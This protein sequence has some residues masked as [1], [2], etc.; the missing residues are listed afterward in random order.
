M[1]KSYFV[2]SRIQMFG[3]LVFSCIIFAVATVLSYNFVINMTLIH[4]WPMAL[5][6]L[7]TGYFAFSAWGWGWFTFRSA[8]TRIIIT[9]Q[10]VSLSRLGK[11]IADISWDQ[12]QDLG[13]GLFRYTPGNKHRLYISG[14]H[15]DDELRRH[16]NRIR[17]DCILLPYVSKDVYE[18]LCSFCP[19]QIS[20]E[21]TRLSKANLH[22][23]YRA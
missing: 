15:L 21:V 4:S 14:T 12:V 1:R 5:M 3:K 18:C 23:L 9:E 8:L 22:S 2:E 20:E 13:I 17:F 11:I 19:F 6:A 16:L 7:L 10:N